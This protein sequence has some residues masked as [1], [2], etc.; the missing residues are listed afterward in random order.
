MRSILL[1]RRYYRFATDQ[2]SPVLPEASF[3]QNKL[4]LFELE[5]YRY[6]WQPRPRAINQAAAE[7]AGP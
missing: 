7:V 2:A 6:C 5:K 4:C 1:P 3:F